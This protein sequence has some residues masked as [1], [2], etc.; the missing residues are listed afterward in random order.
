MQLP[1]CLFLTRCSRPSLSSNI[2]VVYRKTFSSGGGNVM[3]LDRRKMLHPHAI[4]ATRHPS[5]TIGGGVNP[6]AHVPFRAI[7]RWLVLGRRTSRG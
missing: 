1:I 2:R 7:R 6:L 3:V 4:C 5:T